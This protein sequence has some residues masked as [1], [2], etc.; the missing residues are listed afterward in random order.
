MPAIGHSR[1]QA[2]PHRRL[3]DRRMWRDEIRPQ[4]L[5]R[6]PLCRTCAKRGVITAATEVD[7]IEPHAGDMAL[8]RDPENLQSLC[9]SCHSLKTR[10]A[11]DKGCDVNGYPLD[12][13]HP[14]NR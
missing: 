3:Y 10:G 13:N 14:W 6:E 5:A 2:E 8:F 12:P 11:P 7:H 4:Q 1:R 9:K